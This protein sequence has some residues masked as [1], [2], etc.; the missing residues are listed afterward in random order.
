MGSGEKLILE[1][2][3]SMRLDDADTLTRFKISLI[4]FPLNW[5]RN[6]E[7][8]LFVNVLSVRYCL[9]EVHINSET[10]VSYVLNGDDT[11]MRVGYSFVNVFGIYV[12]SKYNVY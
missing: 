4:T 1:L 11:D 12:C 6:N 8:V 10:F 2:K 5:Y 9:S 7:L 3:M